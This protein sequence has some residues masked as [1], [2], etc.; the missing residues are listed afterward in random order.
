M[1]KT[2]DSSASDVVESIQD[3]GAFEKAARAGHFVSGLLHILIGYIAI[4]LAFGQGGNAD[5]SGALAELGEKPG[6]AIALWVAFVAFVALALWRV[7]EAI[8]GKKSDDDSGSVMDR[9]KAASLALVYIV[10]AWTT[11][12]FASGSGKSSG[13]QNASMTADLMGNGFGKFVLV[14]VGLVIIGVGGYHVYKGVSKNFLDDLEGY[15][16]KT[17]ER[18][19]IVG[20]CAKGI[21]LIGVGALVIAAV[22]TSDPSKATGMDGALKTL[23]Q[24][25]FGQVL[26]IVAGVGIALYGLYSFVLA[27]YARM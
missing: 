9:L 2:G 10:F 26:L 20:Y 1:S 8:V 4:R 14:V 18:L 5:Q 16:G 11:F 21:A 27:R 25:P 7:V 12:G 17:V 24:Q 22:F 19:G 13:K 6:G 3:N 23:G 15:T